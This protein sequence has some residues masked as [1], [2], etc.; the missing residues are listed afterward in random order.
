[1]INGVKIAMKYMSKQPKGGVVVNTSSI[2]GLIPLVSVPVHVATK[3]GV[4]GLTR[5]YGV[6][7]LDII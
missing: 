5:S 2:F 4:I 3:H 7:K 6:I 1:M